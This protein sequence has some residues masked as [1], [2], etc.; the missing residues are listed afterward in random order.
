MKCAKQVFDERGHLRGCKRDAVHGVFCSQ[1]R[2]DAVKKRHD[3]QLAKNGLKGTLTLHEQLAKANRRIAALEAAI[4]EV[5][6]YCP[7]YGTAEPCLSDW[8]IVLREAL[9]KAAIKEAGD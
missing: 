3:R 7:H 8:C 9:H 5:T 6:G 4:K 1:H 2:P